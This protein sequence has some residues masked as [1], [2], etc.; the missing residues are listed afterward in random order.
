PARLSSLCPYT[1]L[2]RSMDVEVFREGYLSGPIAPADST[3]PV[4][5]VLAYLVESPE[6]VV[7]EGTAQGEAPPA[8]LKP[9]AIREEAPRQAAR[10]EE[11]TSELQ[12]RENLV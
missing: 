10:S 8:A 9:D 12:S 5:G 11:H 7:R 3:V 6:Q 4:G 1:T 2:F